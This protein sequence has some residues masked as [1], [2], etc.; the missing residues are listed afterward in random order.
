MDASDVELGEGEN[1]G[2]LVRLKIGS[3]PNLFAID[4]DNVALSIHQVALIVNRASEIVN[5]F[6]VACIFGHNVAQLVFVK[7]THDILNVKPLALVVI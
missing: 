7:L 6:A 1:L 5:E 2:E 4:I 3:F